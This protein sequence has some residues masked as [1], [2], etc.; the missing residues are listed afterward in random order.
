MAASSEVLNL[1]DDGAIV[2]G[3]SA[4]HRIVLEPGKG[5]GVTGYC[6]GIVAASPAAIAAWCW[7]YCSKERVDWN[8]TSDKDREIVSQDSDHCMTIFH[9]KWLPKPLSTRDFLFRQVWK[10]LDD[11][12]I[13]II[14]YDDYSSFFNESFF[15][16]RKDKDTVRGNIESVFV[17]QEL[18]PDTTSDAFLPFASGDMDDDAS[19]SSVSSRTWSRPGTPGEQSYTRVAHVSKIN[20][21][22]TVPDSLRIAHAKS[23]MSPVY[24]LQQ[25]FQVS[26][27][28]AR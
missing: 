21:N 4:V 11:Y 26:P 28:N 25:H 27:R 12:T 15:K 23:F 22:G 13:C 8:R 19:I 16:D 24:E 20:F 18:L 17:L 9:Q 5:R 2:P 6:K 10:R 1:S 7:D 14:I 3:A